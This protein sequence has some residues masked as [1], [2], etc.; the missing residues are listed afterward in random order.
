MGVDRSTGSHLLYYEPLIEVITTQSL[1]YIIIWNRRMNPGLINN[2]WLLTCTPSGNRNRII[3]FNTGFIFL[4]RYFRGRHLLG[5]ATIISLSA[6]AFLFFH[7]T[8][9]WGQLINIIWMVI[10]GILNCGV[11]P[12]LSGSLATELGDGY[13]AQGSMSGIINGKFMGS[14]NVDGDSWGI[15]LWCGPYSIWVIGNWAG[16]WLQ[17]TGLYVRNY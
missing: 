1:W 14:V 11:D 12:I 7:L 13:N 6:F 4:H 9:S 17:C 15:E 2:Q 10:A 3:Y 16:G 8:S 5:T